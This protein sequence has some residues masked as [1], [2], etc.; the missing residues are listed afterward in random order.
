MAG[1]ERWFGVPDRDLD[2]GRFNGADVFAL[3]ANEH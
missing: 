3:L 2:F 1:G